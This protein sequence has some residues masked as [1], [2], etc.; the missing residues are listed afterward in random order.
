MDAARIDSAHIVGLSMGGFNALHFGLAPPGRACSLTIAGAGYGAMAADRP[1][2]QQVSRAAAHHFEQLGS[3]AYGPIYAES[4]ARG[5][6]QT[7]APRGRTELGA[8]VA[9]H[10]TGQAE[11]RGKG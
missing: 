3:A 8:A 10:P 2:F 6:N 5:Q 4:A 11:G 1:A 7:K 9:G